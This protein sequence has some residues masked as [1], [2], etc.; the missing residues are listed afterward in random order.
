MEK[1]LKVYLTTKKKL[2][3]KIN[4]V[5]IAP[6]K[7]KESFVY[8]RKLKKV[9]KLPKTITD[10]MEIMANAQYRHFSLDERKSVFYRVVWECN[11]NSNIVFISKQA[12]D[13]LNTLDNVTLLMDG[14]F[15]VLPRH[16]RRRFRQLYIISFLYKGRSYPLAYVLMQ[17]KDYN[18]YDLIFGR[19]KLLFRSVTVIGCMTDYE[20]AT[21]KALMKHF[22]NARISGCFFHYVQTI[23]KA[24]KR[25]GMLKEEKFQDALQE[26]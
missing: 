23:H 17:T 5:N 11:K 14:T 18:S 10:F 3:D 6:P 8:R 7:S 25:K 16:F 4:T 9:P 22:P 21:C 20:Q 26:V 13:T 12:L 1:P 2:I 24:F 19:L 15:K